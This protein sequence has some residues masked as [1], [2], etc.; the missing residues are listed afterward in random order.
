V[1]L[2]LSLGTGLAARELVRRLPRR[3][4]VLDAAVA[5]G[6]TFALAAVFRR[7]PRL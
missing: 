6:V 3:A 7:L 2:A 5:A 4:R 1:P